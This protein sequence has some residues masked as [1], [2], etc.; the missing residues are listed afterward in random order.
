MPSITSEIELYDRAVWNYLSTISPRIVYSPTQMAVRTITKREQFSDKK[1]WNF[2]SYYRNPTFE[3]DWSRMNNPATISG[4]FTRLSLNS[5][6]KREARYVNNIPVNLTYSVEI[7]A[8]KAVEVQTLAISLISKMYMQDQVLE[9]PIN[10]DGEDGRFHI[11]DVSWVDNSDLERET[12][13]GKIYRHT[14]SFTVDARITL[15]RDVTTEKLC[16]CAPVNIYEDYE[17]DLMDED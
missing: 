1:P 11:L 10:P 12:E 5:A 9:V 6:G 15:V 8:S 13:I 17:G 2:I 14:I 4:D 3:V 7:W 16:C